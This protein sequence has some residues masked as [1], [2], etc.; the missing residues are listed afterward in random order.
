MY[1]VHCTVYSPAHSVACFGDNGLDSFDDTLRPNGFIDKNPMHAHCSPTHYAASVFAP[2][3]S[4]FVASLAL[5]EGFH[6]VNDRADV[7]W[8]KVSCHIN[9]LKST[10][11]KTPANQLRWIFALLLCISILQRAEIYSKPKFNFE[12]HF[13]CFCFFLRKLSTPGEYLRK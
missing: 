6:L 13:L 4:G 1:T 5:L 3:W 11:S 10:R 2:L 9:Q 8:I 12:R 7:L